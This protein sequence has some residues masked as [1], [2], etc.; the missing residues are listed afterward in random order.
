[1]LQFIIIDID[2]CSTGNANCA[3]QASCMD[4]DGSFMCICNTGYTGNGIT[5]KGELLICTI[6]FNTIL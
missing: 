2:E 6:N 1:M 3:E 5:C 4:T